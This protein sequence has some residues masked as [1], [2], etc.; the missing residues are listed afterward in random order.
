[1]TFPGLLAAALWGLTLPPTLSPAQIADDAKHG[2]A[3]SEANHAPP[4]ISRT[5]IANEVIAHYTRALA[6]LTAALAV[7]G[8]GG[9]AVSGIEIWFLT[10]AER[11]TRKTIEQMDDTARKQLRAYIDLF[12]AQ[13]HYDSSNQAA[14]FVDV[15]IKNYG[16]TP[17]SDV[18]SLY[19]EHVREWP[20]R[21]KLHDPPNIPHGI[22]PLPPDRESIQRIP[23]GPLN[24]W[25]ENELKAGRAGIYFWSLVTYADIYGDRHATRMQ[26]VCEGDG[27]RTGLMHACGAPEDNA[28]S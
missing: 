16:Q 28:A 22:A 19:G 6:F 20:L 27:I 11:M 25:L 4:E 12:A 18:V 5:E 15:R 9:L 3:V 24:P 7:V 14:C 26:L 17:A 8:I 2:A 23:I 1:M 21:S 10:R 13:V